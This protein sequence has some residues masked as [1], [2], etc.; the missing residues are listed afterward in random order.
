MAFDYAWMEAAISPAK[1]ALFQVLGFYFIRAT[2][3][4]DVPSNF[5]AAYAAKIGCCAGIALG[6][7]YLSL[8]CRRGHFRLQDVS[9]LGPLAAFSNLCKEMAY[10]AIASVIGASVHGLDDRAGLFFLAASGILGPA[11]FLMILFGV[12]GMAIAIAWS[13]ER[14]KHRWV[15]H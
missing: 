7:F 13:F 3:H 14:F 6:A 2:G 1:Y 11:V 12:L 8:L 4:L 15:R 9:D 10:T 5:C